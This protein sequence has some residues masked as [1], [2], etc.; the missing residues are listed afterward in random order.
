MEVEC[1]V[2]PH[3]TFTLREGEW[4]GK[5]TAPESLYEKQSDGSLKPPVWCWWAF[6]E[7][8]EDALARV[9]QDAR[10]GLARAKRK[11]AIKDETV[12]QSISEEEIVELISKVQVVRLWWSAS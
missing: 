10:E 11:Q 3:H 12:D 8:A 7:T 1:E 2:L 5:I 6:F 9:E 4:M